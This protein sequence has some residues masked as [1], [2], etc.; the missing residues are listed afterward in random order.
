MDL[1]HVLE[2]EKKKH[3]NVHRIFKRVMSYIFYF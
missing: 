2:K 1:K 3:S